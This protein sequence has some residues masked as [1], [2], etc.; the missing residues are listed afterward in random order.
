M[1]NSY[2]QNFI[3]HFIFVDIE[4]LPTMPFTQYNCTQILSMKM[5][6]I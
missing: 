1:L 3:E 2:S 5:G 6:I 4:R